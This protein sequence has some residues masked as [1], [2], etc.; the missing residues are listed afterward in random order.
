MRTERIR[1]I[2]PYLIRVFFLLLL[3]PG[4]LLLCRMAYQKLTERYPAN[5]FGDDPGIS[6]QN[7]LAAELE[8][9]VK[10]AAQYGDMTQ[11]DAKSDN[12]LLTLHSG[13]WATCISRTNF[14]GSWF[15]DSFRPAC[16]TFYHD[17][18]YIDHDHDLQFDVKQDPE[19]GPAIRLN[20]AWQK[21]KSIEM[22]HHKA[23]LPDGS[24]YIWMAGFWIKSKGGGSDDE[25]N[26]TN[27]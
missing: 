26:Q 21:C 24:I 13:S 20:G 6:H 1:K 3:L 18:A 8:N 15:Q 25:E 4:N 23:I 17:T 11:L 27:R 2:M 9:G 16:W 19:N 12:I 14:D 10:I 22:N 5:F 7:F